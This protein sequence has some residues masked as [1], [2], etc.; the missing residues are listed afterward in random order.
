MKPTIILVLF[1]VIA[2][3]IYALGV[4]YQIQGSDFSEESHLEPMEI[5]IK[6]KAGKDNRIEL[7]SCKQG[8]NL[9]SIEIKP[10]Q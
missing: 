6:L 1:L 5:P 7:I 8:V 4:V 3:S 9:R 2:H 10:S